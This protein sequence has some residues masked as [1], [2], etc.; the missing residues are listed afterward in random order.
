MLATD[1]A[2]D[3]M[4]DD[5]L[6]VRPIGRDWAL[7]DGD[8]ASGVHAALSSHGLDDGVGIQVHHH[9]ADVTGEVPDAHTRALVRHIV[10]DAPGV[11]FVDSRVRVHPHGEE[12]P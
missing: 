3:G 8:I 2:G 4:V 10:Q 11:H 9:T 1:V 7:S 6:V 12:A 5:E